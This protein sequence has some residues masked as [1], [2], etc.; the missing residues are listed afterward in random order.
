[1]FV[2][3]WSRNRWQQEVF[4]VTEF[5]SMLKYNMKSRQMETVDI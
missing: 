3:C 2:V 1:M 4:G 5:W